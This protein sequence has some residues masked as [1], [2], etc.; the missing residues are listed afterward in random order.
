MNNDMDN[1]NNTIARE[2][3]DLCI[4]GCKYWENDRCI[5]CD[6]HVEQ[7]VPSGGLL[8]ELI[9]DGVLDFADAVL[10]L[11]P[12]RDPNGPV[13][14]PWEV[15]CGCKTPADDCRVVTH[16]GGHIANWCYSCWLASFADD[17][18]N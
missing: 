1:L 5:D 11:H 13:V 6:T 3:L 4:C 9:A 2:G 12:D 18:D 15:P 8:R 7:K 17:N 14:Y 10:R 16:K